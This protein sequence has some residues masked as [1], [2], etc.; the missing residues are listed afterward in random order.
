[1]VEPVD[2]MGNTGGKPAGVVA[3]MGVRQHRGEGESER[4]EG[5]E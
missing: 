5:R 2:R 4:G 3:R 1:M